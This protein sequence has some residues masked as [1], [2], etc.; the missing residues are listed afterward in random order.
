MGAPAASL[1][2]ISV[3]SRSAWTWVKAR[4]ALLIVR[5]MKN[6]EIKGEELEGVDS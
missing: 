3:G 1:C 5:R 4:N 2:C 6:I